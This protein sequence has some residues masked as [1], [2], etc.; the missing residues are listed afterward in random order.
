MTVLTRKHSLS[1]ET[2]A[3]GSEPAPGLAVA[4]S[5]EVAG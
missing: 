3:A 1:P 5:L 2:H 4:N